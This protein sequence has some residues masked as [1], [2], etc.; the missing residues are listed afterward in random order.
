MQNGRTWVSDAIINTC[1][2]YLLISLGDEPVISRLYKNINN[3]K[4]YFFLFKYVVKT[5]P[6]WHFFTVTVKT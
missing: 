5:S 1:V 4:I 2:P 6:V 3:A